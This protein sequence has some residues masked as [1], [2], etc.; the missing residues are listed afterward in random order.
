ME[1]V[2]IR[3]RT[4]I[5][6]LIGAVAILTSCGTSRPTPTPASLLPVYR[7]TTTTVPTTTVPYT[8]PKLTSI[9][10]VS[11]ADAM[12][13]WAAAQAGNNSNEAAI[14]VSTDGGTSWT[15]QDL[16]PG[17]DGVGPIDCP[18]DTHC[19]A[20]ADRVVSNEPPLLLSTTD[21]GA[22]WST[23]PM[24]SGVF[25]VDGIYCQND[26]DC[27]LVAEK[28]QGFDLVMAT[29]NWGESW[30][31]QDQSSIEVSMSVGFDISCPST[32]D[33]VVVGIGSLTTTDGGSTWEKHPFSGNSPGEL[34]GIACPSVSFCVAQGDVTSAVPAN[35]STEIATSD[36]GGGTWQVR[37][38]AVGG[39]VG[40]LGSP[41]CPTTTTCLLAGFGYTYTSGGPPNGQ[42]TYWGAVTRTTDGG[43]TWTTVKVPQASE[44][45]VFCVSETTECIA[46]GALNQGSVGGSE[47]IAPVILRSLDAGATWTAMPVPGT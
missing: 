47:Q 10:S 28:P 6:I 33:C 46:S 29:T 1:L 39:G 3:R 38:Q 20:A 9:G 40:D 5:W 34:N 37:L 24:S 21:G 43:S 11:C 7:T 36:D 30:V 23:Q 4:G 17:V 32:A 25:G 44:L 18:S 15:V 31:D 16:I 8:G 27:W 42:V 45:S 12:H 19:M 13:C 2:G 41:S 22:T 35:T 26:S 14:L